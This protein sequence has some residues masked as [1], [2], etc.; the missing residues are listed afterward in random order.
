MKALPQFEAYEDDKKKMGSFSW[1]S[2]DHSIDDLYME[3]EDLYFEFEYEKSKKLL[4]KIILKDPLYSNAYLLL[5][6][7]SYAE[8]DFEQAQR[9]LNKG[10]N[11]WESSIP[12]DFDGEIPWG[13]LENRPYLTL[14]FEMAILTD[15][16]GKPEEAITYADKVLKYNPND[17]QGV[18]WVIGNFFLK[19]NKYDQA[20][21]FL[22]KTA[23][24]YPPNRYS[25]ALLLMLNQKRWDAVSQMR[26]AFIENIYIYEHL[27]FKAPIVPYDIFENSNLN[28]IEEAIHYLD[29]MGYFWMQK[30]EELFFMEQII[31]HPVV[32]TELN[33]IFNLKHELNG[34]LFDFPYEEDFFDDLDDTDSDDID[35]DIMNEA[36]EE[37]F[38]E[39]DTIKKSINT[40]SSKKILKDL[41]S[42]LN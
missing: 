10:L 15:K 35:S 6:T 27:S 42:Y 23:E 11:I 22:K 14:L 41:D 36:R 16:A 7:L 1:E 4:N 26:M 17:N 20:E 30:Q 19:A 5:S 12:E 40:T 39:I 21:K 13:F 34:V 8:N 2:S 28:S 31:K 25:Y 32:I 24:E 29:T 18:R 9:D 3:A 37:I 33:K 38:K